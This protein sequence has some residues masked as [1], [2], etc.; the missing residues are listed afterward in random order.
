MSDGA[1]ACA[2][3]GESESR[4]QRFSVVHLAFAKKEAALK[5]R[6]EE[7]ELTAEHLRQVRLPLF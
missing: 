2:R 1:R 6:A 7:A 4:A 3:R 5:E